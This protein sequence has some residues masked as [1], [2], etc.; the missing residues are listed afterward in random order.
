MSPTRPIEPSLS[1]SSQKKS[2]FWTQLER[3]PTTPTKRSNA[4]E[5]RLINSIGERTTIEESRPLSG[6][7]LNVLG[8]NS[9]KEEDN[10]DRT[11]ATT[12]MNVTKEEEE[13]ETKNEVISRFLEDAVEA[14]TKDFQDSLRVGLSSTSMQE[15][16]R[17]DAA[18]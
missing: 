13:E 16:N 6:T 4:D 14:Q 12:A 5:E 11:T 15:L 2:K 3:K 7:L 9:N 1:Q 18:E 17:Y 8:N 10:N